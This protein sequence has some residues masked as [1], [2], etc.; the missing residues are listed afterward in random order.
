[1]KDIHGKWMAGKGFFLWGDNKKI[2]SLFKTAKK[3]KNTLLLPK[4]GKLCET[5]VN[6]FLLENQEAAEFLLEAENYGDD[7][8]YFATC[9]RFNLEL[10]VRERFVPAVV[11][12]K[13]CW[14]PNFDKPSDHEMLLKLLSAMPPVCRSC[15]KHG[16]VILEDFMDAMTDMY[17]RQVSPDTAGFNSGSVTDSWVNALFT[18]EKENEIKGNSQMLEQEWNEWVSKRK[19]GLSSG[20]RTCFVLEDAG[21]GW[22]LGFFL[23]NR[24]DASSMRPYAESWKEHGAVMLSD[25]GFASGLFGPLKNSLLE[26]NPSRYTLTN[27]EAHL[28]LNNGAP[29]LEESGFGILIPKE[30][31]KRDAPKIKLEVWEESSGLFNAESIMNFDWKLSISGET[32]SEKEFKALLSLKTPFAKL[33]GKWV[34][35]DK[36]EL[37][38]TIE[39]WKSKENLSMMELLRLDS[40]GPENG[41]ETDKPEI[42]SE[43]LKELF[44]RLES[45]QKMSLQKTPGTFK[46]TLRDYQQVGFSWM[47][48]MASLG[49]GCCLADDMGLGKTIQFIAFML[50]RKREG[51]SLLVCPTS[52]MSNW[53]HE[54]KRF[55]PSLKVLVHHGSER[56]KG[57]HFGKIAQKY[58]LVITTYALACRDSKDFSAYPWDVLV[59]DEAQN[60][61]NHFTKQTKSIKKMQARTRIALTGTPVENRLSELWSIM[62]FLNPGF[63]YSWEQFNGK[64]GI[65]IERFKD[66]EKIRLLRKMVGPLLLR[67]TKAD[68]AVISDIPE[69]NEM[70]VYCN[71]TKEQA[72]LYRATVDE[73][74]ARIEQSEGLARRGLV[75]NTLLKLKQ[76]CNH[77][78]HLT[79]KGELDGR[80][81]K[82]ER[83]M[84]MIDEVLEK[85]EKCLVFTQYRE[86]GTLLQDY[87]GKKSGKDILF[88]HGGVPVSE[89]KKMVE[90]FQNRS[91]FPVFVL[92][93]KAGGVGL[94]LTAASNVFHYDRW[95]NPAVENQATDRTYRIGQTKDVFVHKMICSGTIEERID[96]MIERK[97]WLADN[98]VGDED[99]R[100][101]ELST[102]KLRELFSLEV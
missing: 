51:P 66:P 98:V 50:A 23:Q 20:L 91:D 48:F 4:E 24:N 101:T 15:G 6:G 28:F 61:K 65:P 78:V 69:K 34:E 87:I 19:A 64:F 7:I 76:I 81:G 53:E 35:F 2:R 33:H 46:G 92:S 88:F 52:L 74:M 14:K 43:R 100:I 17:C 96:E 57:R 54:L 75:L 21:H 1:M 39:Y 27:E 5:L 60:I 42:R 58:D 86:M 45:P 67:R 47:G 93:L 55:S 10:I 9:L 22:D 37:R 84:E 3:D 102:R 18:D 59:L 72:A 82:L 30:L 70:K 41:L 12:G 95:W 97:K 8:M 89:R 63:L 90:Q 77:P 71:L 68:R 56:R 26:E 11:N 79:K 13:A 94:N 49:M 83:L 85:N 40:L 38:R 44:T 36:E 25:L 62:D 32:L 29:L 31:Q 99:L 16:M 80:S 73:M